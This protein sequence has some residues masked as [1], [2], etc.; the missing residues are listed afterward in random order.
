MTT[1]RTPAQ[2]REEIRARG[3]AP[4]GPARVARAEELVAQA[5][6]LAEAGTREGRA[7]LGEALLHLAASRAFGSPART[8]HE[9]VARALRLRDAH[10]DAFGKDASFAL[11]W[12][13]RWAVEDLL[14]DPGTPAA[15]VEE[16][17][18]AM[19]RR[20]AG[21]GL[22]QRAVH[23]RHFM[24]A[25][26]FG[27]PARADRAYAAW[28]AAE[29]DGSAD[30]P[31]CELAWRGRFHA[32][33]ARETQETATAGRFG[34]DGT[35]VGSDAGEDEAALRMWEPV[36]RGE[37]PCGSQQP[38]LLADSLL[39]LLRLGRFD[40]ARGR[41]VAGYLL[42]RD[43]PTARTALARHLEFCALTGNEPRGLQHLAEQGTTCWEPHGDP[44]GH[45]AWAAAVALLTRRLTDSGHGTLAVPG[46]EGRTWT[47]AEL[48]EY[49]AAR[50][51]AVAD[52][53]DGR[54]GSG[55]HAAALR[56]RLA[57]PPLTDRLPLGVG[58]A[59]PPRAR[60]PRGAAAG[61]PRRLLAE[62]RRAEETGD[63]H[64]AE[65]WTA[66]DEAATR[67]GVPLDDAERAAL[68]SHRAARLART[69][70]AAAAPRFTEAAALFASAGLPG[71]ALVCRADAAC[72]ASSA[73]EGGTV[74][75]ESLDALCAEARRLHTEG[76]VGT[77]HATAVL[78]TRARMRARELAGPADA[79]KGAAGT[80][81][82]AANGAPDT[83]GPAADALDAELAGLIALAEPDRAEPPVLA[84]IAEAT[85][86]RGRLA[87]RRGAPARA[88][89]LLAEAARLFHEAGRPRAASGPELGLARLLME[90]GDHK[91]AD[92]V[93]CGA[94]EDRTAGPATRGPDD[95][96]RFHLLHADVH[97][98][99]GLLAEEAES[100]RHAVRALQE[101]G[102]GDDEAHRTGEVTR[103]RLRLGGCLLALEQSDEA[104]AVLVVALEDLLEAADEPGIVQACVWL[105]QA[106]GRPGQ[107]RAA[108][109]LLR[110]A[111]ASPRPWQ[112]LHGHAVVTHLAADIHRAGGQHAEAGELYARAEELW[113]AL[114]DE[115]ALIRTLHARAWLAREA[116]APFEESLRC[117]EAA[118]HEIAS[119]LD[120]PGLEL[121][122]ERRLR[123]SLEAGRTHRQTAELLTEPVPLPA[124]GEQG[125]AV[126]ACYAQ[127]IAFADRAVAAFHACGEAGLHE[128]TSA[129]LRAAGLEADLGRY[130]QAVTR[131][132][133][134]RAAYPEGT[135]DPYGTVA[136]R[137]SEAGALELRIENALSRPA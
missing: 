95:L 94:L 29:R 20:Y 128:A 91:R 70:P 119:V 137:M 92:E 113:R 82:D 42:V 66:A 73:P 75:P 24:A 134:V 127:G 76:R 44:A 49:A 22:S 117:M 108:A 79:G 28:L 101:A 54:A 56:A 102:C 11:L 99:Q 17:L 83:L 121:D 33:R 126:L 85:E 104:A 30:C 2:M 4:H 97:A 98:A 74:P 71:E 115:Q 26:S 93:L 53:F 110:R 78:L 55:H 43:V 131:L 105:G 111:A 68:L 35:E 48:A 67:T 62:A 6:A 50:A 45:A 132:T 41:H 37:Y 106:C 89:E 16:W 135:P 72:S 10:P 129:E 60:A 59:S 19:G 107:L 96:A 15:E 47:A 25:R 36:L 136:E 120:D 8:A 123:L 34:A 23:A 77:R 18:A 21:A 52:R 14:A 84:R 1:S 116:G 31:G 69:D 13:L 130:D 125:E 7:A 46:P 109:R 40:E 32:E 118:Q 112:D 122:D 64:A 103:A 114:G 124:P 65:L 81:F 80:P 5:G 38:F 61:D 63:P 57:T 27:D 58:P 86:T 3:L 87:A 133:R 39:P 9:P 88:A 90:T 51:L 12:S 100:L